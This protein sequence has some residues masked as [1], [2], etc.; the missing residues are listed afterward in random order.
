MTVNSVKL[1]AKAKKAIE[2]HLGEFR[3]Y[4][5]NPAYEKDRQDRIERVEFFQKELSRRID[6]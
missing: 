5:G 3:K 2:S 1:S 4:L 6:G